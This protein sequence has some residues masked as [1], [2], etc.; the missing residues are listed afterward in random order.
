MKNL[1]MTLEEVFLRLTTEEQTTHKT[2]VQ[3]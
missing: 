2:E 3:P 1:A